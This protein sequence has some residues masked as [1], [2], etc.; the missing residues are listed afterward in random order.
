MFDRVKA[1][2]ST[3]N[4]WISLFFLVV[5]VPSL[6]VGMIDWSSLLNRN[7]GAIAI[8]GDQK[9]NQ[10]DL[11]IAYR[12]QMEQIKQRYPNQPISE[13]VEKAVKQQAMAS[14]VKQKLIANA[15]SQ[16]K[17]AVAD[18]FL[19]QTLRNDPNFVINGQFDEEQFNKVLRSQGIQRDSYLDDLRKEIG[20]NLYLSTFFGTHF[21]SKTIQEKI[22][23]EMTQERKVSRLILPV[24]EFVKQ[25]SVSD[26][27]IREFYAKNSTQF[28]IPAT[29]DIEYL[30]VTPDAFS[31]KVSVTPEEMKK[32]YAAQSSAPASAE[33][34][35]ISHILIAVPPNATADEKEKQLNKAK[36][37]LASVR[38]NPASFSQQAKSVSQDPVS[39]QEGGDLGFIEKGVME[40][41]FD[42]T[43]FALQKGEVSDI[44]TTNYGFHILRVND[45]RGGSVQEPFEKVKG[46]LEA[47]LKQEKALQLFRESRSKSQDLAYNNPDN[48][49]AIAKELGVPLLT[50]SN[51][52]QRGI[53]TDPIF[54]NKKLL[55]LVFSEKQ[56]SSKQTTDPFE[57]SPNE[58]LVVR[59]SKHNPAKQQTEQEV[60]SQVKEQ[61]TQQAAAKMAAEAGN[62]MV[63]DLKAGKA[64]TGRTFAALPEPL[65][66]LKSTSVDKGLL[67]LVFSAPSNPVPN[68]V[69]APLKSGDFLVA[70]IDAVSHVPIESAQKQEIEQ[71]I[72]NVRINYISKLWVEGLEKITETQI[73]DSAA[74]SR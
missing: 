45:I 66:R 34:R 49:S 6:L 9:I 46:S 41:A 40:K 51:L 54:S 42:D 16:K 10:Q 74:I 47:K 3:K 7:V 27:D 26:Q 15:L 71:T 31:G 30:V 38:K 62:K 2:L 20:Q 33:T 37:T 50:K 44:V 19:A 69:S 24:Q 22:V 11:E 53:N 23:Q 32:F 18:Q 64:I 13:E 73:F 55:D 29:V 21:D 56:V 68:Y 17:L 4:G 67:E 12:V 39:A 60:S 43:A 1:F 36:E 5:L 52:T 65:S 70:R 48:L 14:L 28:M 58:F 25:V 35:R 63:L 59:V 8:V 61:L 72:T 57:L